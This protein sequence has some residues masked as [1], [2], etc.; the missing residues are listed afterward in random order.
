[1]VP[2]IPRS[3]VAQLVEQSAVNR[4]VTG[5][6][7]VRGAIYAAP[8]TGG[9]APFNNRR[10][11]H[12]KSRG[13]QSATC[14]G[15]LRDLPSSAWS[16]CAFAESTRGSCGSLFGGRNCSLNQRLGREHWRY[17]TAAAV[18]AE[19]LSGLF[20]SDWLSNRK[21]GAGLGQAT[22]HVRYSSSAPPEAK[23][24]SVFSSTRLPK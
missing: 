7:P 15:C 2:N 10:F 17:L 21:F 19:A 24:H 12:A 4:L 22:T 8:P 20:N 14:G 3:P 9:A 18:G 11:R 5:S 23:S 6:S 13:P 16:R 1:M